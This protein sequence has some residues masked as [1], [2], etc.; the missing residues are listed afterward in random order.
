MFPK[1]YLECNEKHMDEKDII[2]KIL[3]LK[4]ALGKELIILTHHYQRKEIIDVGHYRGD[5]LGLSQ[6]AKF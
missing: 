1:I 6:K 4:E 5:S 3:T 2:E